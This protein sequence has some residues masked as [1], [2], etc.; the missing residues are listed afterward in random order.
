MP[1]WSGSTSWGGFRALSY[2]CRLDGRWDRRV[3]PPHRDAFGARPLPA[4]HHPLSSE[5]SR[6]FSARAAAS[7]PDRI[8]RSCSTRGS[9]RA[10]IAW[11][12]LDRIIAWRAAGSEAA[13]K[14]PGPP[15]VPRCGGTISASRDV[16][17]ENIA[18]DVA[19]KI[20]RVHRLAPVGD[21]P[22]PWSHP[23]SLDHV[24]RVKIGPQP[25]R[26]T[27]SA[28]YLFGSWIVDCQMATMV[29]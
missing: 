15:T 21:H 5:R 23:T 27:S 26:P 25:A 29:S 19:V 9:C 13:V 11:P 10:R 1:I 20:G 28:N 24:P 2:C 6:R 3:C 14:M 12:A 22:G 18:F 4:R 17:E 16:P 8:C 7:K